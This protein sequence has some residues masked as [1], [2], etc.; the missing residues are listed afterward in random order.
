MRSSVAR[1]VAA[2]SRQ[3]FNRFTYRAAHN[4]DF[5]TPSNKAWSRFGLLLAGAAGTLAILAINEAN[6]EEKK[7]TVP[8]EQIINKID[9]AAVRKD[10]EALLED[11]KYDDG[12]YGPVFIRLAWHAAGTYDKASK[13]GGSNGATMR[14]NGESGHGANAGLAIARDRLDKVK[15]KY[16]GLSYAD[17]WT[18][19]GTV[20]IEQM[21]G[22]KI[23][24]RPG[25]IDS[26]GPNSPIP[27]GRLPDAGKKA[28]HV[29]DVFY[30][31]G[32]TDQEIVALIGAHAVGRCHPDRSGFDGP[33]THSPTVFSNEFFVQL[34]KN[35]W[36][37]RS[38]KG[39]KQYE[40]E[41]KKLMM[42]PADLAFIEDPEFKKY[43]EKYAKDEQAFFA[44]F[45]KAWKKLIE[46]GVAYP[47]NKGEA[48]AHGAKVE[49]AAPSEKKEEK[50]W[51][52]IW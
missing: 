42:L 28:D 22:P 35:K 40:D 24:W 8:N 19:A 21:G 37:E 48:T 32:F 7:P 33:W 50:P 34:L 43:V 18:L 46:L 52:K 30:R 2:S 44:D 4:S 25:R 23:D 11:A 41:S 49:K 39:P 9:Y 36:T 1:I 47:E 10:I 38:W 6:A 13:T 29:R 15:Q 45:A 26:P 51:W 16:P 3:S 20:A 17:L 31:M 5:V 27:D 14:F 12:S